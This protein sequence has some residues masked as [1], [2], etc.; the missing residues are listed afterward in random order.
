M[1]IHFTGRQI[2]VTPALRTA[3]EERLSKLEKFL[4]SV[5]EAHVILAV[6]KHRHHAEVVVHGRHVTLSAAAETGDMYSTLARVADRLERQA[7]KH[8]EKIKVEKKRQGSRSSSRRVAPSSERGA[9]NPRV[10]RVNSTPLKP[11]SVEEA[12]L[13]LTETE[14]EFVVFRNAPS[15]RVSVLYRRKDGNYGLI[16]PEA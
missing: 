13:H 3:A 1:K 11:M 14:S 4:D 8:R 6:E 7:K 2:D 15:R 10:V 5:V 9:E 12:I 16:E